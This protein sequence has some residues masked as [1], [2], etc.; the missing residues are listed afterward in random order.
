M[1]ISIKNGVVRWFLMILEV[2]AFLVSVGW[3]AKTFTGSELGRNPE[4]KSLELAVKL[5]PWNAEYRYRLGRL[6][7]YSPQDVQPEKALE[8]LQRAVEL[9]PFDPQNWVELGLAWTFQ[10]KTLEAERC[11]RQAALLAPNIPAYQWPIANDYLMQGNVQEAFRHF[12]IVL[13]GTSEYDQI[14]FRTAWKSSDDPDKILDQLIPHRVSTEFGY[15]YY[16]LSEQ[17]FAESQAV[18]T[19]I[20]SESEKFKPQQAAPYFESL[21][22]AHKPD[23]AYQAWVDLQRRGLVPGPA[24]ESSGN[25][26]IN[27]DFE[28]EISNMGFDWRI[29]R[30]P[31][32]YAGRDT[33]NYRSPSHAL[34]VQFSG[35]ENLDY[36]FVYQFV[37]VSPKSSYRLQAFMKTE[38]I[39]TDSGPRLEVRDAYDYSALYKLTDNLVGTTE[40]WVPILLDFTAG[41]KTNLLAVTLRRPPSQRI[42]NRI[43]GKVWLDDLRITRLSK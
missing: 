38:G 25:A 19:R 30:V 3:V 2:V 24:A 17:R 10:G 20:L 37:K 8:N 9:N 6:Y 13:A 42:D 16:L 29:S 23:Q 32:V 21:I 40:G 28:E 41:P 7:E 18:W 31:G 4:V 27:G 11:L 14:V 12:K 39:T 26:V 43:A 1:E 34:L 33:T 22:R 36:A 15:L 5:D 35:K